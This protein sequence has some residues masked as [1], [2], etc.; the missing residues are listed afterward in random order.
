MRFRQ[1]ARRVYVYPL[2]VLRRH[3]MQGVMIHAGCQRR[4]FHSSGYVGESFHSGWFNPQFEGPSGE[5]QVSKCTALYAVY[6]SQFAIMGRLNCKPRYKI[7]ATIF[8]WQ[9]NFIN[10]QWRD[11]NQLTSFIPNGV[12]QLTTVVLLY[13]HCPITSLCIFLHMK[14][15]IE[16]ALS[17]IDVECLHLKWII[18]DSFSA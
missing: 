2:L 3:H 4:S 6:L 12:C 15:V 9:H 8:L 16:L 14:Y 18:C 17:C 1:D 11:I 10:S 13:V 7:M 5:D